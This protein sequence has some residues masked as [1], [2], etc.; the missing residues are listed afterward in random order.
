MTSNRLTCRR[1]ASRSCDVQNTLDRI[2]YDALGGSNI[3][4]TMI[5]NCTPMWTALSLP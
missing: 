4:E 2:F 5:P 1:W 3:I